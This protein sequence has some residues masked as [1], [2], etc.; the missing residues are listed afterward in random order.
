MLFN[1]NPTTIVIPFKDVS[2]FFNNK[3]QLLDVIDT[4]NILEYSKEMY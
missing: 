1:D 3:G 4:L 2:L